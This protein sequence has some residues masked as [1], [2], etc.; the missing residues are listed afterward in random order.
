MIEISASL[1]AADYAH[2]A[3][4]VRRADD[5]GVDS[6][7]IDFMDGHYVPNLALTPQH[8]RALRPYTS[9]PFS[10]HLEVSNP[11]QVM[12]S[13]EPLGAETIIVQAD[14]CPDFEAT[15]SRIRE[16]GARVGL[17]VNPDY[18]LNTIRHWLPLLD[19]LLVLGVVPGFGGQPMQPVT[20]D[21]IVEVRDMAKEQGLEI[22]IA[23]DGGVKLQNAQSLV[24]AG[25]NVLIIG[26]GLFGGEDMEEVVRTLKELGR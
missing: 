3:E 7:H 25:A 20:M 10:I 8:L 17:A 18:P 4:D 26:T 23:V 9:L 6:F 5:A 19:M 16:Q 14:T 12:E 1:L 21:N 2:M 11:D 13:F 15:A 24:D 22:S